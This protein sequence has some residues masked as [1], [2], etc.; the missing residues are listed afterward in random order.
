MRIF[1]NLA[2]HPFIDQG[3]TL[4][5]LRIA[6]AVMTV[7]ALGL[8]LGLHLVH[9]R[10]EKARQRDHSL[11]GQLAQLNA[12]QQSYQALMRQP[13]NALVLTQAQALNQLFNEKSF[14]WT[15]AMEDLETVLPAGVQVTTLEPTRNKDGHITLRLR[16][17]GPRDHAIQ[18]VRNLER[19]HRFLL[20]RIVGE[21]SETN[22]GPGERVE[23]I[24][25]SSRVN[26]DLL[27][28]Y[29]APNAEERKLLAKRRR[30]KSSE[31]SA[32]ALTPK[33]PNL[34]T[35]V[36]SRPNSV[37]SRPKSQSGRLSTPMSKP[38]S[39]PT[40]KTDRRM[41]GTKSLPPLH[42]PATGGPR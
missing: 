17:L 6:M 34:Q 31:P 18:L 8:W 19:S 7:L 11:D 42:A 2:S 20:P 29:N 30:E 10:A 41:Q 25:A 38:N 22:G 26:F 35:T 13:A 40:P 3:P 14:S 37:T 33:R 23:A 15:L 9:N 27:A 12:E 32:S 36:S 5:R 16:V 4:R 39:Q 28:E 24:S 1:I 21:N